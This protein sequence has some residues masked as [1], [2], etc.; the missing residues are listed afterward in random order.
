M[1]ANTVRTARP[2]LALALAV[3]FASGF[4]ALLYQVIWQRMLALFSGADVFS[5]TI[6][7]AAFMA[8]LGCGSLA[9]GHLADRVTRARC[10]V[11]FACAETAI[12]GFAL[13][14]RWIFYDVL[15]TRFGAVELPG[16]A[17]A[18]VLFGAVLWPTFFMGLSL[19]LLARGMSAGVASAPRTVASLYG[20]N[21]LGAA[22]GALVTTWFLLR[23]FDM[24]GCLQ[25]GAV[26][27]LGC[28][29]AAVPLARSLNAPAH[30]D[31]VAAEIAAERSAAPVRPVFG[32]GGWLLVYA[33]SGMIALSLEIAWFRALG[34]MLKS[35]SFTFGTLLAV[36]LAGVAS[37][38]I[39]G[40]RRV[41]RGVRN[42]AAQFLWIQTAVA[43]YAG[44]SLALLIA[45][46]DRSALLADLWSYFQR[47][48]GLP[49]SA[50]LRELAGA[51]LEPDAE[52]HGAL[53]FRLYVVLP[54]L[55]I[56]PPTFLMGASFPYLQKAV[57]TDAVFLGRRV[58]WLQTAN[59]AGS[60]FGSIVTGFVLLPELGTAG[61]FRLL[62]GLALVFPVLRLFARGAN[63][64]TPWLASAVGAAAVALAV[65]A[66]P[67]GQTFWATLHGAAP[68]QIRF[69]E[70]AAGVSLLR[71]PPA[72]DASAPSDQ[73]DD[74]YLVMAGGLSLSSFP[75]GRY[76]GVHT[77]L[78]ALPVLIHPNPRRVA[79][80]GVGSGD[81]A[82]GAAGRPEIDQV[83]AIEIL[84]S[85][86]ELLRDFDAASGDPGLRALLADPRI[87]IVVNDG[88]AFLRRADAP[89]DV[90]EAD[91]LR[92]TS[93]Y[94][95]NLYSLEYFALLRSKLA[96]G[97]L[98]VTWIPTERVLTTFVRSFP[99]VLV[100]DAIAIGSETPI[101][102]DRA[103]LERR[104]QDPR[105]REHFARAGVDIAALIAEALR[106]PPLRI[107]PQANRKRLFDVNRD[108][109]AK[110]EFMIDGAKRED[111]WAAGRW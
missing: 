24:Q 29:A 61:T 37:G 97:G 74:E 93:A 17:L 71:A 11:W 41:E 65:A 59:I 106:N 21:T 76:G 40:A 35:M 111:G 69:V 102:F 84:G 28:A 105:V 86:V 50:I 101:P 53:F 63:E 60:L 49:V 90:I 47:Q 52:R 39:A 66:I 16:P 19:P 107:G 95:G 27:N 6:I 100:I 15:Y 98:A 68:Q 77:L 32:L 96:P 82:Y 110:D 20:F 94:A 91:A 54:L 89:F 46:L 92:P 18:A 5:V 14:S 7:V 81:T 80:I 57:Q 9:G 38:S 22:T 87:E 62:A 88:R 70:D 45:L 2:S 34:V 43:V 8:G 44:L 58:G 48:E 23:H 79:V 51:P 10:L 67:A 42:P 33:L 85:Q 12:A 13:A 25:I 83:L 75:F 72:Q 4:A 30:A 3:F 56:G 55:L 64:R 36:Y 31:A 78:G 73:G 109:F 103:A 1:G 26:L 99:H 108:L 104:A